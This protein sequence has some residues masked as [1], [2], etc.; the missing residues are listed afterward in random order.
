MH[1][2]VLVRLTRI[3]TGYKEVTS[4]WGVAGLYRHAIDNCPYYSGST[5]EYWKR[6]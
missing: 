6:R 4:K 1:G 2:I 3:I 5:V